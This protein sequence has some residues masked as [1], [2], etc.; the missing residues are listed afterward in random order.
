MEIIFAV[1]AVIVI[2]LAIY[3]IT[4]LFASRPQETDTPLPNKP[5]TKPPF[6]ATWTRDEEWLDPPYRNG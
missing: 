2:V 1:I 4:R 5:T 3:W 6:Q